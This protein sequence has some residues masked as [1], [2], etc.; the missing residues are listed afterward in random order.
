MTEHNKPHHTAELAND[1]TMLGS[2][3]LFAL[4][5]LCPFAALPSAYNPYGAKT[6]FFM[7]G[8][9]VL[10]VT[11]S[12]L[13]GGRLAAG[14][15]R[16]PIGASIFFMAFVAAA[17]SAVAANR[18]LALKDILLFIGFS[19]MFVSAASIIRDSRQI[20]TLMSVSVVAAVFMSI[21]AVL[22]YIRILPYWYVDWGVRVAGMFDDPNVLGG[23][24]LWNFV[25]AIS[26][27]I[28]AERRRAKLF[29]GASCLMLLI[30]LLIS[31]S[32]SAWLAGGAAFS[33][34]FICLLIIDKKR[35]RL[36]IKIA[37]GLVLVGALFSAYTFKYSPRDSNIVHRAQ[38]SFSF[39]S[40]EGKPRLVMWR[41]GA[42]MALDNPVLGVGAG[43]LKIF[44]PL[45]TKDLIARDKN[46]DFIYVSHIYND[47]IQMA[48][49][50]G[51]IGLAALLFFIFS[52]FRV[53]AKNISGRGALSVE[54]RIIAAALCSAA[55]GILFR[56]MAFQSVIYSPSEWFP[57]AAFAGCASAL[58]SCRA[59]TRQFDHA[60]KP[61]PVVRYGLPLVAL[62]FL[63]ACL[64][65]YVPQTIADV[66]F[67]KSVEASNNLDFRSA[68]HYAR[69]ALEASPYDEE[70][71]FHYAASLND[72][73]KEDDALW[74]FFKARDIQPNYAPVYFRIGSIQF[75]KGRY[76]E[77]LEQFQRSLW[78]APNHAPSKALA[79]RCYL[80]LGDYSTAAAGYSVLA[81]QFPDTFEY[82]LYLGISYRRLMR[83]EEAREQLLEARRLDPK[84]Q[85]AA[86]NLA[87]V[88]S[89]Q[90]R[91]EEAE[92]VLLL[93]LG[94][95][96]SHS[97]ALLLT[98]YVSFK[99]NKIDAAKSYL[100]QY[101]A[102]R[103]TSIETILAE[104]GQDSLNESNYLTIYDKALR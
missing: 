61:S 65:I 63:C 79:A 25:F 27:M 76:A 58:Q 28:M 18:Y 92:T 64:L 29:W 8:I 37:A 99:L 49:Q 16:A 88:L 17:S 78:L 24:V 77:A 15:L 9:A 13:R 69:R 55:A 22:Q 36:L 26:L 11:A 33:V 101:L 4:F 84:S 6:A 21:I 40:G 59:S 93:L 42:E 81:E 90:N 32:R 44:L 103:G 98:S 89:M 82:R 104:L 31:Y 3:V 48:A 85:L 53:S 5:A 75:K 87:A 100:G 35:F 52:F 2:A 7:T 19:L 91:H 41:G 30:C 97:E 43:N 57:L 83:L 60:M 80:L 74:A 96:S 73:G 20:K 46:M 86:Y 94:S 56:G 70:L 67:R 45:Y 62:I 12:M 38:S 50:T 23:Y 1:R 47:Y 68:E 39:A 34:L 102:V 66:M 10:F 51:F 72:I 95:N 54:D 71:I 14:A